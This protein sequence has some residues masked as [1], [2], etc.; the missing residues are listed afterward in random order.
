MASQLSASITLRLGETAYYVQQISEPGDPVGANQIAAPCT[1]FSIHDSATAKQVLSESMERFGRLDD[2][3]SL[4]FLENVVLQSPAYQGSIWKDA[5]ELHQ[6]YNPSSIYVTSLASGVNDGPYFLNMGRLHPAY[7]LYPDYAGA[8]VA[9]TVPTGDLY[10]YK[11]LDA[12]AYGETCPSCLTVAV[13]SRLYH[14]PTTEQPFAGTRVGIKDIMDLSGLR[15]G[16]S[17]RAY[18][19]LHGPRT[20][21]ADVVQKILELGFIVVGKL[22]TTQFADS[23]WPTCDYVDY[24]APSTRARTDIKRQAGAAVGV[25]PRLPRMVG[26]ILRSELTHSGVFAL[27]LQSKAFTVYGPRWMP[28]A[29]T[30]GGFA[31]DAVSFAKLSRALYGTANDPKFSKN[32]QKLLYPEEYWPKTSTDHDAVLES[33]ITKLESNLGVERT[34]FSIED[35]WAKTKPVPEDTTLKKYFEHVFEWA[36]N[37]PQWRDFLGPFIT[38]YRQTHGRDPVLNPQLQFKRDYLPTVTD[39]QEKEG[40]RRWNVF[41]SW[42]TTNVLPPAQ[43]GFSDTLLILLW[44]SGKPDYRDTYRD[45]PQRFTGIGFFFYNLSPYSGSPEAILPV[46]QTPFTSRLINS[47]EWLPTAIGLSSGKGSDVMLTD[48]IADFISEIDGQRVEVGSLTF[49]NKGGSLV[50]TQSSA[51]LLLRSDL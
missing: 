43:E 35:V 25:Q 17:S 8:F 48:L 26:W 47:T 34:C 50:D 7:R 46:G 3:W 49:D 36:A 30:V 32:P 33:F 13:P 5:E 45:G 20:E 12:A 27:R 38:E 15:T 28:L 2:V 9:P 22:K 4:R 19:E 39:E 29:D 31:R 14:K 51:Q 18:T 11:P 23:E 21:N 24:H 37:T 16:D 41:E 42:Y 1:V 44:S 40:T 10:S 6:Q